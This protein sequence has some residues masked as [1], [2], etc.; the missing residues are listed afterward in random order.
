[1]S[2]TVD[3]RV[4]ELRFDNEQFEKAVA[5]S[6]NSLNRLDQ[7]IANST[8]SISGELQNIN[9]TFT[10][11][12]SATGIKG[13][14][15]SIANK[16]SSLGVVGTTVLAKLTSSAVDLVS[17]GLS[18]LTSGITKC[19]EA[20]IEGGK[21][22][23]TNL[24]QAKFQLSGLG[25]AWEEVY[26]SIDHS[27][28]G[29]A[30]ALDEAAL[31]T[32]QLM[33]S[34]IEAGDELSSV[35]NTIS[36]VAAVTDS[37]YSQV[38][39]V[40]QRVAG[41]GKATAQEMNSFGTLGLN[42]YAEVAKYLDITE[43]EV[44]E[45][46]S[47]G[48]IGMEELTGAMEKYFEVAAA[49]NKTLKTA[50]T[51]F[52]TQFKKIGAEFWTPLVANIDEVNEKTGEVYYGLVN[53]GNSG[54]TAVKNFKK[55][56]QPAVDA[57]TEFCDYWIRD[58]DS[59]IKIVFG[60]M[61]DGA[62]AA[63]PWMD[64]LMEGFANII[65]AV[66]TM[67][68]ES[69]SFGDAAEFIYDHISNIANAFKEWTE[70][71]DFSWISNI[72]QSF[73]NLYK[74]GESL[75]SAFGTGMSRVF[76]D[77]AHGGVL[78]TI[79]GW[80]RDFT[81]S[82]A[83]T[84]SYHEEWSS[85]FE[86]LISLAELALSPLRLLYEVIAS[87]ADIDTTFFGGSNTQGL[88][89]MAADLGDFV[90]SINGAV[91]RGINGAKPY[92]DSFVQW[93]KDFVAKIV[94]LAKT[95]GSK[96]APLVSKFK[97]TFGSFFD[98]L[99]E[100]ISRIK[101]GFSK[102]DSKSIGVVLAGA[103]VAL[104]AIK[105]F[106]GDT[107]LNTLYNVAVNR[108]PGTFK[109][110]TAIQNMFKQ[111]KDLIVFTKTGLLN[112]SKGVKWGAMALLLA[113]VADIM[114]QIIGLATSLSYGEIDATSLIA[115]LGVCGVILVAMYE[116]IRKLTGAGMFGNENA[117]SFS[118]ISATVISVAAMTVSIKA[119]IKSFIK[120]ATAMQGLEGKD[121]AKT[122]GAFSLIMVAF[123]GMMIVMSK[124]LEKID[125]KKI[126]KAALTTLALTIVA[127]GASVYII[128]DALAE[129]SEALSS[130]K[131]WVASIAVLAGIM[132]G[133]TGCVVAVA[134]A[135][136]LIS[137]KKT[138]MV[139]M[140]AG[141]VAFSDCVKSVAESL[142]IV[143]DALNGNDHWAAT[144]ATL[145]GI[146]AGLVVA[147]AA[148]AAIGTLLGKS[149]MSLVGFA[150]AVVG[151]VVIAEAVS[152]VVNAITKLADCIVNNAI[153]M[154]TN[155]P[156]MAQS[157]QDFLDAMGG[158]GIGELAGGLAKF[159]GAMA[160]LGV[161]GL[162]LIPAS[163]GVKLFGS[164]MKDVVT[165]MEKLND[166]DISGVTSKFDELLAS[167]AEKSDTMTDSIITMID[168]WLTKFS[169][170]MPE[171]VDKGVEILESLGSGLTDNQDKIT[172][173]V[174]SLITTIST[175][176]TE[177][178]EPV[179]TALKTIVD[180]GISAGIDSVTTGING[181]MEAINGIDYEKLPT[182][183]SNMKDLK[184][185]FKALGKLEGVSDFAN[186]LT[187]M[188][189]AASKAAN[190]EWSSVTNGIQNVVNKI[191]AVPNDLSG[192]AS[193]VSS[194]IGAVSSALK[195]AD[196]A[197]PT[198]TLYSKFKTAL[199]STEALCSA[200]KKAGA[201]VV[202]N[203][204]KPLTVAAGKQIGGNIIKGLA[205]GMNGNKAS[206]CKTAYNIGAS[207]VAS[208]KSG[209]T[210]ASPS[211]EARKTGKFIDLGLK[212][213]MEDDAVSVYDSA[214]V[215]GQTT[216]DTLA[217]A[218]ADMQDTIDTEDLQPVI[219]P[220]LDLSEVDKGMQNLST[221]DKAF[222]VKAGYEGEKERTNADLT[223][224]S[225]GDTYNINFT[226]TNNS[227]EAL[228]AVAIYRQTKSAIGR[229]Q[230]VIR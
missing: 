27:V 81:D 222:N 126:G 144:I 44:R 8:N 38:A 229:V 154:T 191:K 163:V 31:A 25:I 94:D 127:M 50:T 54:I 9:Q 4:V 156:A 98:D 102:G 185:C 11:V 167:L 184:K 158:I 122:I 110:F 201:G 219:T 108:I 45:L 228:D 96:A 72:V 174:G 208:L 221:M 198:Q 220:E 180:Q 227:P 112:I 176:V 165:V 142:A 128:A 171:F 80:I 93:V 200:A 118:G 52:Y 216:I 76:P 53:I 135:A 2:T 47:A 215:L 85:I 149:P 177:N 119:L 217:T 211:K 37:E 7:S 99:G 157:L 151:M 71:T 129:I 84:A 115:A 210:V 5:T 147:V 36:G 60:D 18:K 160:L 79:T 100:T 32:G 97:D 155:L 192:T 212:L 199:N 137:G 109:A 26:D 75:I 175:I 88:L 214:K 207:V 172:E 195:N 206:A 159:V 10:D 193:A 78:S 146:A 40:F 73:V 139:L 161:A 190:T 21:T 143:G 209:A 178:A 170:K 39:Q 1:M 90:A 68:G 133:L 173:I 202:D 49:G 205:Q 225:G 58:F 86:G 67:V 83:D 218:M 131:H 153:K 20:L 77:L 41:Y 46:V 107:G 82:L 29:T 12:N 104:Y 136:Q 123:G 65:D 17:N 16:F 164:G 66:N 15:D 62:Y 34:G 59:A 87:F 140:I 169:E 43:S 189:N 105:T 121:Y 101:E 187:K 64:D 130:S 152:I 89:G 48:E 204:K 134:A 196:L 23:A 95:W 111:V 33:A 188:V 168:T 138:A 117:G 141:M 120:L 125:G 57:W 13:S 213:G 51:N 30:F 132:L 150:A 6:Q 183:I 63:Q 182:F 74:T 69:F 24:Q 28:D 186:A 148:M 181:L 19:T 103:L 22:R 224:Q 230:G 124:V 92:I 114:A 106:V 55:A 42:A 14:L 145:G 116:F 197:G 162:A 179:I 223:G 35:L 203:L 226:Q 56:I 91:Q 70:Y 3:N 194:A 61:V 113:N 166:M